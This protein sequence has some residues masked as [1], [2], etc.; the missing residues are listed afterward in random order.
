VAANEKIVGATKGLDAAGEA[1]AELTWIVSPPKRLRSNGLDRRQHILHAVIEFIEQQ[2][3]QLLPLF[4]LGDVAG[5]LGGSHDTPGSIPQGR[6]RQGQVDPSPIPGHPLG[7]KVFNAFAAP[8][9]SDDRFFLVQQVRGDDPSYGLTDHFLGGEPQD[10]CCTGVPGRDDPAQRLAD[11]D[12][13]RGGDN[14]CKSFLLEIQ[15]F[16][17]RKIDEQI[18][19]AGDLA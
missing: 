19:R 6:D 3:L 12:V 7:V 14:R 1:L 9:L 10:A 11:D 5:N 16:A 4:P 18:Y 8:H 2:T 15:A 17:I 13:I